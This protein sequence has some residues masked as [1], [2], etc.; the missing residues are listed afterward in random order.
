MPTFGNLNRFSREI[1][2]TTA[3]CRIERLVHEHTEIAAFS[4]RI[5]E[6]PRASK[7][8]FFTVLNEMGHG[9]FI[10]FVFYTKRK[11]H[12]CLSDRIAVRGKLT[13]NSLTRRKL[14]S[15]TRFTSRTL[16]SL[17]TGNPSRTLRPLRPS[18]P[19]R[20]SRTLC[21]R[22]SRNTTRSRGTLRSR[23]TRELLE[24]TRLD[25][26]SRSNH[27][28]TRSRP[29]T[30]HRKHKHNDHHNIHR[31]N[32]PSKTRQHPPTSLSKNIPYRPT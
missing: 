12:T 32:P 9:P 22:Y 11:R 14:F 19:H 16:F 2:D 30:T 26:L 1:R 23:L 20:T 28:F 15:P 8:I 3:I 17:F 18:R 25:L 21:P 27:I 6:S 29:P 13:T 10:C 31:R 4:A 5:F 7:R 24:N